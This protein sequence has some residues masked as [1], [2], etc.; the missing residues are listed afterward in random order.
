MLDEQTTIAELRALVRRFVAD[1][2]WQPF[3]DPKNLSD[4]IAVEAAE[5]MEVYQWLTCEQA[6]AVSQHPQVR[7][8]TCEELADVLIYCLALAN[9]LEIDI[10]R[11]IQD[12]MAVNARK[13]PPDV[14]RGRLG[15][16]PED[17]T[18]PSS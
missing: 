10:S 8:H 9:A 11:A 1:R 3:Q 2:Q 12:K 17:S 15:R 7:Q 18:C 16:F 6:L 5:L 13:Y 4:A 14:S